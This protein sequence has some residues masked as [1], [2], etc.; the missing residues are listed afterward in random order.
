[1]QRRSHK[2]LYIHV[3]PANIVS[4]GNTGISHDNRNSVSVQDHPCPE[5]PVCFLWGLLAAPSFTL[6]S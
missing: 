5:K 2:L 4:S 6:K 3:Q 1:M